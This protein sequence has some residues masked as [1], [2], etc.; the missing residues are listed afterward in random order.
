VGKFVNGEEFDS[1]VTGDPFQFVLGEG[2]Y[3]WRSSIC[4]VVYD[5]QT[6]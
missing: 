1:N 5:C 2:K 6:L 3:S 4:V